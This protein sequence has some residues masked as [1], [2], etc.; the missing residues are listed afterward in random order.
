[1]IQILGFG[2]KA[3]CDNDVWLNPLQYIV[4]LSAI[5]WGL[6][7]IF[8]QKVKRYIAIGGRDQLQP[9]GAQ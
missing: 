9:L 4:P 6:S 8:R 2:V 1:M 3:A 7:Q 5:W